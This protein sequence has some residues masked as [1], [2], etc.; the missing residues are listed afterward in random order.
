MINDIQT[1]VS[2]NPFTFVNMPINLHTLWTEFYAMLLYNE[3]IGIDKEIEQEWL[4]YMTS[5]YIPGVMKTGMFVDSK[6]YKILHDNEDGTISFSVQYFSPSI[7]H[8]E[9]YLELFAPVLA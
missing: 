2:T 7:N 1:I 9:K 3:T 8:I 4:A 5:N 6:I